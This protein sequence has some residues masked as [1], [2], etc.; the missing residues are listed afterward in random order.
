MIPCL[1]LADQSRS[2]L[3]HVCAN[4]RRKSQRIPNVGASLVEDVIATTTAF[5]VVLEA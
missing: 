4:C 5:A 2:G 3:A 1:G